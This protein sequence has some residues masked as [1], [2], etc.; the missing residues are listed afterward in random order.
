MNI[1]ALAWALTLLG[2]S[3]ATAQ[4]S[5]ILRYTESAPLEAF[6]NQYQLTL[7]KTVSGRPIHAVRD[8]LQRDPAALVQQILDDTDDDVSIEPD[9][10]VNL[11][12][13]SF[14]R[15]Q[16]V[17]LS[18]LIGLIKNPVSADHFGV[19]VPYAFVHQKAVSQAFIA[20][21]WIAHGSGPDPIVAVIDTGIDPT[22][23]FFDGTTVP[24]IDFLNPLG[25]GSELQD[26]PPSAL[27]EINPTTTPLLGFDLRYLSNGHAALLRPSV[28]L[29]VA[30]GRLPMGIG[31]GTMVAGAVLLVAPS[32][33]I[34]P[35]R[36][37]HQSGSGRLFDVIQAIHAAEDRG[38]RIANLSFNTLTYSPELDRSTTEV[39][40]RG[41]ILV[42]ST[43]NNGL[44]NPTSYPAAFPKV[45][46]VASVD[47][48]NQRS[49]FSNF[50]ADI[51]WVAAPGEALF[52]P[53][54]G[55][56]YSV[57][58]G[59]S[60]SAPLVTGLAV[61]LL[62]ANP[63]ATGSDLQSSLSASTPVAT[64]DLGKGVLNV[65]Q[66]VESQ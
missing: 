28:R 21:S 51:T 22:H 65:L 47:A 56:H 64:P 36:A 38:A 12:I 34:L 5:Y 59:T 30:S 39:S 37:F 17:G 43:G 41:M 8:P 4:P 20:P 35:I 2:A 58:W 15:R 44:R 3:V 49:L 57:G 55:G 6:L 26:L 23:P 54:P 7:E 46:S 16:H 52:L 45:T 32:A 66:S 29:R 24:G 60:F 1:K 25:T 27:A 63:L 13:R 19:S 10:V 40:D 18:A 9:Q 14:P 53:F 11:P 61:R 62:A 50:G 33:R 31:H 42:A 48:L